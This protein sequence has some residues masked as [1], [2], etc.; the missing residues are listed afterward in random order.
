MS[1]N[2][3]IP[4]SLIN[5]YTNSLSQQIKSLKQLLTKQLN[6]EE[7]NNQFDLNFN[8]FQNLLSKI[9]KENISLDLLISNQNFRDLLDFLSSWILKNFNSKKMSILLTLISKLLEGFNYYYEVSEKNI[10]S[11][12]E[13]DSLEQINEQ[14]ETLNKEETLSKDS[15]ITNPFLSAIYSLIVTISNKPEIIQKSKNLLKI[16]S[17]ISAQIIEIDNIAI[18]YKKRRLISVYNTILKEL[19]KSNDESIESSLLVISKILM[20]L[21]SKIGLKRPIYCDYMFKKAIPDKISDIFLQFYT[22]DEEI[23]K[24][25]AIYTVFSCRTSDHKT[26]FWTKGIISIFCDILK[27]SKNE[28]VLEKVSFAIYNLTKDSGEIQEDLKDQNNYLNLA[29][30][31]L[32]KYSKNTNIVFNTVSTL[33]RIKNNVFYNKM[34]QELLFTYFALFDYYY[35]NVKKE[36]EIYKSQEISLNILSNQTKFIVLKELVAILGNI[37]KNE[38]H[39]K[40]FIEKNFHLILVDLILTFIQFPK[41]IKNTIGAL[42]NLTN[43][44]E[45]REK[46][47]KVAAFIESINSLLDHY[48]NNK[49][50]VEYELKLILNILKNENGINSF[51]SGNLIYFLLLFIKDFYDNESIIENCFRILRILISKIKGIESFLMKLS[52]FYGTLYKIDEN[53]PNFISISFNYFINDLQ[54]LIENI[55][56]EIDT[57]IQIINFIAYLANQNNEFKNVIDKNDKLLK[58]L[59][60]LI[61]QNSNNEKR[62]LLSQAIAQLPVEELNIINR[63]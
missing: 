18:Y 14:K 2:Y 63:K 38:I 19:K 24:H 28:S 47:C 5:T 41:L 30:E 35:I 13:C 16:L 12:I 33:R 34:S 1:K 29:K 27:K 58:S 32:V 49:F 42:I 59:N 23:I 31:L 21:F 62:K 39:S 37:S 43:L 11:I 17:I 50:I 6:L 36:I 53:D 51:I 52:E 48:K 8:N 15:I 61:E 3:Q 26:F 22:K 57:K 40:P 25:F 9:K 44:E 45:I 60:K 46:L 55:Y 56:F 7:F 54:K 4:S 10:L 20:N